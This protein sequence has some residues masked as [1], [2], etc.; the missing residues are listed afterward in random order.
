[1][2]GRE[3]EVFLSPI[4]SVVEGSVNGVRRD[5]QAKTKSKRR[6]KKGKKEV[7]STDDLF[8]ILGDC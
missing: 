5:E 8:L 6:K 2:R 1:V 7:G 3:G 4:L